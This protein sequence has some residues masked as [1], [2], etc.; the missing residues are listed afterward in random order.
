MKLVNLAA[1]AALSA[2][3][4]AGGATAF[5]EE[6]REVQTQG[7]VTFTP[8]DDETVVIPPIEPEPEVV[9]PP[10]VPSTGPLTISYA[11]TMNFGNQVIS[12]QDQT[13]DMLAEMQELKDGSG[14]TP[15]V[16]F[17]QVQDTRGTNEG[18]TLSVTAS[19]FT[20][21]TQNGVLTGAQISLLDPTMVYSGNDLLNAPSVHASQLSLLPG[22]ATNVMAADVGQG[23]G[24]SS[25]VWG[26]QVAL[27]ASTDAEVRN[28]AIQLFVPGATA[29]DATTYT[30]SLD[31]EL[32]ATPGNF[33]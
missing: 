22:Q 30:A 23:A 7:S 32:S 8:G 14:Q 10:V 27:S 15:Y 3:I 6:A 5:A 17:A 11:P 21:S 13:Y 2:S 4:L 1:V 19:E 28:D 26:D 25:V 9:I 18:W 20:S 31:W 29:K 33:N 16:S 24:G 12:N